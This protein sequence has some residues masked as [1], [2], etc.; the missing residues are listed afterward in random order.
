[1][2]IDTKKIVPFVMI[3]IIFAI[4]GYFVGKSTG[5]DQAASLSLLQN[6]LSASRMIP[7][8]TTNPVGGLAAVTDAMWS[9]RS[10]LYKDGKVVGNELTFGSTK[11]VSGVDRLSSTV[12]LITMC[13][14]PIKGQTT[15]ADQY[16][17]QSSTP[18]NTSQGAT[19][20]QLGR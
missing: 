17:Y 3:A 18:L 5:I 7:V 11:N 1:M 10:F 20:T 6:K 8:G 4:G 15:S 13:E 12:S 2:D 9:C 14:I 16:I 19:T